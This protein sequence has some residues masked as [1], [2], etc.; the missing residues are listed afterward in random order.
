MA[1]ALGIHG[2][3]PLKKPSSPMM[4]KTDIVALIRATT[5]ASFPS[6]LQEQSHE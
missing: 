6:R 2:L 3:G 4:K 1:A 5:K